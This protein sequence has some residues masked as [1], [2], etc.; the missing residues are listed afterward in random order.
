MKIDRMTKGSWGKVR[1]FFD[2]QTEDG[3]TLKGFKLVEG[4][5]GMFVGFPSQKDEKSE[6][7][8]YRDTV[9]ADRE[10]RDELQQIAI[11]AY[12]Q[13]SQQP[14]ESKKDTPP[15][16]D[17]SEDVKKESIGFEKSMLHFNQKYL[18]KLNKKIK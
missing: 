6:E 8:K 10:L 12:G 15:T 2:L 3:F 4:I 1:A 14:I 11:R 7:V 17:V 18:D 13:D 5:N 9:F 16:A